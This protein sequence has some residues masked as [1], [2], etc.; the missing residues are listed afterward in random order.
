MKKTLFLTCAFALAS[1]V[2]VSA[3]GWFRTVAQGLPGEQITHDVN[4]TSVTQYRAETPVFQVPGATGVRYTVVKTTQESGVYGGGPFFAMGEMQVFD[5]DGNPVAYTVTSNADHNSGGAGTD[6]AGLPALNDGN[7]GNFFHS[8]WGGA[9]PGGLHY[10]ELTFEESVDAFKLVWYTR[11]N[12]HVNRPTVVGLSSPGVDFTEDMLY[13][14]YEYSL[15]A[16][17]TSVEELAGE[18]KFFTFYVEGPTEFGQQENGEPYTGP[19]N[20][21]PALQAGYA[22]TGSATEASPVNIIQL[23]AGNEGKYV[24]YEPVMGAYYTNPDNWTNG[25]NGVNGNQFAHANAATLAEYEFTLRADGDFELTTYATRQYIDDEWQDYAEPVKL[26]VG[27]DMRGN[28][29]LFPESEKVLLEKGDYESGS[30]HLPVDFGFTIYNTN[31][32]DGLI[33]P[34]SVQSICENVINPTIA[35]ARE[36]MEEYAEYEADYDDGEREA[37][38][39]AIAD[40]EAAIEAKDIAGI[41][42][43]KDAVTEALVNYVLIKCL[44]YEDML[45][46]LEDAYESN[47]GTEEG[48]YTATSRGYI[49]EF[50]QALGNIY[51]LT[52]VSAIE[53]AYEG[54]ENLAETFYGSTLR[55]STFPE[56][57]S[58]IPADLSAA[59]PNNAVWKQSIYVKKNVPGIRLTFLDR[60]I[61]TAGD[62]GNFPMI[63]LGEIRLYDA[64]GNEVELTEANFEANYTE[65]Q[66][67]FESTVARLCDG[68]WGEGDKVGTTGKAA[69]S[70]YHSPWSGSEPQEYIWIDL[71]FPEA[72]SSFTFEVYSRDKSTSNGAVSLFP[73]KVAIT[74]SNVGYDP[75][76]FVENP[77]NV[78]VGEQVT[79]I[80]Q[81]TDGLYVVKGLLNTNPVYKFDAETGAIV[82]EEA[83]EGTASFYKGTSRFHSAAAAVRAES[84]YRITKNADGTYKMLNLGLAKYWPTTEGEAGERTGFVSATYNESEAA[85][86]KIA[87]SGNIE[88]AF[89]LYEEVAGLK[90]VRDSIDTDEDGVADAEGE[91]FDTPYVVY[92]DWYNG[93]AVRPV[94]APA[95]V[96]DEAISDTWGDSLCFNKANGEGEW[97]I[98]K[99][100]MD[101]PD[102]YWLTNLVGIVDGL[103][104]EVGEDPGCVASLG[105]LQAAYDKALQVVAD[106]TYAEATAAAQALAK[107]IGTVETLEK[108]PMKEGQYRIV[109]A[110]GE[111]YNQQGHKKAIY[112]SEDGATF[113]WKQLTEEKNFIFEFV[114]SPY[115]S[116]YVDMGKVTEDEAEQI[117]TI[118]AFICGEDAPMYISEVEGMSTQIG[119]AEYASD[120]LVKPADGS[121]FNFQ[122]AANTTLNLHA[123]GHS[124]G[125][126]TQGTL[127]YWQAAPGAS[128][129]RLVYVAEKGSS[130]S[131]LLVEGTEV[132]SVAYFTPAG[133]AVPAPVKGVNVVVTVY[134]NGV[135]ETK[136]VLVK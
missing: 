99:V 43:A 46:E 55:Y 88:N 54:L 130:V 31:V 87:A 96:F 133:A 68:A 32:A 13:A 38:E 57:V 116:D 27:Y 118:R 1:F 136:K 47:N 92:M 127:V 61:G 129:W 12:Q 35:D 77:Y 4:G 69:G 24:I 15:G 59:Y 106:S 95:P 94:V 23:I 93:L 58:D 28:L 20:V 3:Q 98:Y 62:S 9:E 16:Q 105:D 17:V 14:E 64:E 11:P 50:E 115:A 74:E 42:V 71:E 120:Y 34:I 51:D 73:K 111:F 89:V 65:T 101:N 67:G 113:G 80:D 41:F 48:Q 102:F 33:E 79:A 109:S 108:N 121:A 82:K 91:S 114:K 76:L 56:I 125:A 83:A 18:N 5:A 22:A 84:V 104:I 78:A 25:Y 97:A 53:A 75:L 44:Y 72:M 40:A 45:A 26:W 21:Y 103:G 29:K 63:A 8:S 86:L 2:G 134:A 39:E 135:V 110:Y 131:D 132:V 49:D 30:F 112:A 10:L 126:G 123:G 117:Y 122:L 70:Y 66:E 60:H 19:G 6:G 37:L 81:I 119:L 90:T 7:Y 100:E 107:N 85:N 36:K 128:Q 124:S 52:S